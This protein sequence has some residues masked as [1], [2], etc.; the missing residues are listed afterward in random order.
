MLSLRNSVSKHFKAIRRR[1]SSRSE[2]DK[3]SVMVDTPSLRFDF[4]TGENSQSD[5]LDSSSALL[6]M[7]DVSPV[8]VMLSLVANDAFVC[9]IVISTKVVAWSCKQHK[10]NLV[11]IIVSRQPIGANRRLPTWRNEIGRSSRK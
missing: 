10:L 7:V 2:P 8:V 1:N 9:I 4:G 11:R 6:L 5:R 3:R